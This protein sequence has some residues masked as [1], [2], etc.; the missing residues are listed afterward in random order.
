MN[1]L[2]VRLFVL[3]VAVYLLGSIC[4]LLASVGGHGTSPAPSAPPPPAP[5]PGAPSSA[6]QLG[7]GTG[8][9]SAPPTLGSGGGGGG[10][11]GGYS[12]GSGTLAG[13]APPET[14]P[15]PTPP[16]TTKTSKPAGHLSDGRPYYGSG[17]SKDPFRDYPDVNQPTYGTETTFGSAP[18]AG[19]TP[20]ST[21]AAAPS[22]TTTKTTT[23]ESTEAKKPDTSTT[24]TTKKEP[25]HLESLNKSWEFWQSQYSSW[26]N[27]RVA[28]KE[29]CERNM[30][31]AADKIAQI[32][33]DYAVIGKAPPS[34]DRTSTT[35]PPQTQ[36]QQR[37]LSTYQNYLK[38]MEEL[39]RAEAHQQKVRQNA[40]LD[41]MTTFSDRS[42]EAKAEAAKNQQASEAA[43]QAVNR[44]RDR[45]DQIQSHWRD[46]GNQAKYGSLPSQKTTTPDP[47][48]QPK[49]PRKQGGRTMDPMEHNIK[50][51]P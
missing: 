37:A 49:D 7:G 38:A 39:R 51:K 46:F 26:E 50:S 19:A 11:G 6:P 40:G 47:T 33:R 44:A 28:P 17:T 2:I 18:P 30:K 48:Y 45:V 9:P 32:K 15:P 36:N 8:G 22:T 41:A 24:T 31:E 3:I 10:C 13:A 27:D 5:T 29:Q 1:K 4:P 42:P 16:P 21:T 20:P 25:T 34:A 43:A 12:G 35:Y 14:P 23:T